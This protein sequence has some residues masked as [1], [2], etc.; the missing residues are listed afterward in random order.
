VRQLHHL[1]MRFPNL[2]AGGYD[3]TSDATRYP[4][5]IGAYN[6]IAWAAQ[7]PS[8]NKPQT[9]RFWWPEGTNVYW[10]SWIA[11][12]ENTVACFI[13]TFSFLGYTLCD[14][15]RL[16]FGYD[17]VALYAIHTTKRPINPPSRW[18]DL[19]DWMPTHMA[20]QLIDGTWT[21][22]LGGSEDVNHFT[23]DAIECYGPP[24]RHPIFQTYNPIWKNEYGCPVV[25]MKRHFLVSWIVRSLQY[26]EW[27]FRPVLR[28]IRKL[29]FRFVH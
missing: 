15:S 25:Y 12:P 28:P 5:Q 20:R 19:T 18:Q 2:A 27:K 4:P 8:I 21:S 9:C 3:P 7:D 14:N 11:D 6:C 13:R 1:E 23:L 16:E 22:K 17:K 24:P 29:I 10:P 26:L